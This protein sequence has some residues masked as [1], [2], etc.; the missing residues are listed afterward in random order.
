MILPLW[1]TF[2]VWLAFVPINFTIQLFWNNFRAIDG[3]P[4][5]W[6]IT[7][8][9]SVWATVVSGAAVSGQGRTFGPDAHLWLRLIINWGGPVILSAIAPPR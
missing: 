3:H 6:P 9:T 8:I 2:C 4:Y 7:V 5:L 1:L